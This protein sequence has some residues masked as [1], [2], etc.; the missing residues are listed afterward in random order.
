LRTLAKIILALQLLGCSAEPTEDEVVEGKESTFTPISTAQRRSRGFLI[1]INV[2][3]SGFNLI[4]TPASAYSVS[5]V[6]CQSNLTAVVTKS[7]LDG[8]EVYDDDRS[9]LAKLTSLTVGGI[10]YTSSNP[11]AVDF[12]TWLADDTA[13]FTSGAGVG[14]DIQVVEQL[15]S[16]ANAGDAVH[17]AFSE[18]LA[19]V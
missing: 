5:L 17:Y 19:R 3:K 8:I 12:T 18:L 9:C 1:P 14:L 13:T 6:G 16:P 15:S 7:N 4:T 11:G 2:S 10:E